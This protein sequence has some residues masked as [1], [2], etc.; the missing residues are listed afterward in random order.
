MN[1]FHFHLF[2]LFK[3]LSQN[4]EYFKQQIPLLK[5]NWITSQPNKENRTIKRYDTQC[6]W[7]AF[8][9]AK[10]DKKPWTFSNFPILFIIGWVSALN[11][12]KK[13]NS[14]EIDVNTTVVYV[15]VLTNQ[16]GSHSPYV[17][18][19]PCVRVWWWLTVENWRRF[20]ISLYQMRQFHFLLFSHRIEMRLNFSWNFRRIGHASCKICILLPSSEFVCMQNVK[21]IKWNNMNIEVQLMKQV[22]AN[23]SDLVPDF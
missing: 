16:S 7:T 5:N 6:V 3:T 10:P 17:C 23:S 14:V 18:K 13:M 8:C 11:L 22:W 20:L 21:R 19:C 4:E 9:I 2:R 15:Y 12:K 1:C